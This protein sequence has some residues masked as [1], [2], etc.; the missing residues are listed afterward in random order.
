MAKA[1]LPQAQ[2]ERK[3]QMPAVVLPYKPSARH[4]IGGATPLRATRRVA[5]AR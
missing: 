2:E 3:A 4:S 5:A 1:T